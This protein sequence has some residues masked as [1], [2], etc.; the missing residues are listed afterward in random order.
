[1]TLR[2][3]Q[4]GARVDYT[5]GAAVTAGAVIVQNGQITGVATSD[6]EANA[7]GSLDATPG[8]IYEVIASGAIPT[9]AL[10]DLVYAIP[11]TGLLTK[12][13]SGNVLFG[14][15]CNLVP[16]AVRAMFALLLCCSITFAQNATCPDGRCDNGSIN[17]EPLQEAIDF[18][19]QYSEASSE[20]R[21]S[22]VTR[23]TVRVTVSGVCGSGTI[24]GRD[25]SGV[26]IVLTNA[27]V[28]G[29]QRGRVVNVERWNLDGTSE[30]G[31]GSIIASGYGRGLSVDFA[32]L[33]CN[34]EFA[35]GVTTVPIANR[36]PKGQVTTFGCPRCEWP[37]LQ[38]LRMRKN[39]SQIL[40][41]QPEAIG[42]RSGSS[43]IDYDEGPRVVGLLTWGGGGE[44]LGQSSP[45]LLEAMKGRLPTAGLEA[46]PPGVKEV[47]FIY[48]ASFPIQGVNARSSE[49]VPADQGLI[50]SIT[51]PGDKPSDE[52]EAG[53][54]PIFPRDPEAP[55]LPIRER[56]I[57]DWIRGWVRSLLLFGAGVVVGAVGSF[58]AIRFFRVKLPFEQVA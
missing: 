35:K 52:G 29:T 31:R 32:L 10:N 12:T 6:I 1:M 58:L 51:T 16:L 42:G 11:A 13:A 24:V 7:L 30:K 50:D 18:E 34:E 26:A 23:A 3:R 46:L 54:K 44:G 40:T 33:K 15:I 56:P 45:F 8:R 4:E 36:Y 21:F 27:H 41:W 43:L 22:I 48:C 37:S 5:P 39:D 25:S 14:K 17:L 2:V 9:P 19:S 20:D 49:S 53:R 55:L 38:N 57:L 28:A 47:D